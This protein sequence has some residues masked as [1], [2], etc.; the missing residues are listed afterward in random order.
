[1]RLR[2]KIAGLSVSGIAVTAGVLVGVVTWQ[3]GPLQAEVTQEVNKLAMDQCAAV[4]RGAYLMVKA[5]HEALQ[6]QL[7]A[8]LRV[9]RSVLAQTGVISFDPQTVEWQATN[10]ATQVTQSVSLP[11]MMV[12]GK[13]LGQNADG[14]TYSAIVD[15]VR[16]QVGGTC[17]VFQRMNEAGDMLRV[18]T[19]VAGADGS[20]AIGTYVPALNADGTPNAV[21]SALLAKQTYS[22]RAYVVNGWYH[23]AYAPLLDAQERVI[24]AIYVGVPQEQVSAL[25]QG[26]MATVGGKTGYV[27]VLGGNGQDRGRYIISAGGKRDGE[28]ILD[29]TDADG[30]PFIRSLLEKA[31]KT[32]G[33]STDFER[34][35]WKNAGDTRARQKVTAVTYFEPWDWVIGAGAYEDDFQDALGKIDG[36]IR[37]VI[38]WSSGAAIAIFLVA[39]L[40]A[41]LVGRGISRPVERVTAALKDIAEGEGDLTKR[42]D[43]RTN[44]EIGALVRW[45][46]TFVQKIH[47][48][49]ADVARTSTDVASA[50]TEIAASSEQIASGMSQQ[51]EQVTQISSAIEEMSASV[52]E[53]AKKSA[54]AASTAAQAGDVAQQGGATVNQTITDMRSINETVSA[55][56]TAVAGLG[57]RSE[58]IGQIIEVINDIADQTNLLALNAAIEAARAG[59]YGRG[60]AVVADEV[61]KLADRTTKATEE[62]TGSITAIQT[63]TQT[64]VERMKAG[65]AQVQT[66]VDRAAGAGESLQKIVTSSRDVATMIQ[67]I[68]AAAE[69]QSAAAEQ[70]SRNVESITAVAKQSSEG[71]NQAA[72]AATELSGKAEQLQSL[73]GRFKLAQKA[74]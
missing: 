22:G 53:V 27:F 74:A 25:R 42:V 36:S 47:D 12:G 63:E 20:R 54:D 10:Q 34:Y 52:V 67:S 72:S 11:K 61:R 56:A 4:A 3:R 13:W 32:S 66:G 1:M 15:E 18:C 28:V 55:S 17:T 62:I 23:T 68:A 49:I 44:D 45:F 14:E 43:V 69:E 37:A 50:A 60:F 40:V 19:N 73:V 65:S 21:V 51:T 26:V 8:N 31:L 29:A 38:L 57:Q 16:D 58:Q 48:L 5:Q 2:T 7:Q 41:T 39:G 70:I 9:A 71:T 35:A 24:G 59:E 6:Q 46:N 30:Q 64:A 33:G